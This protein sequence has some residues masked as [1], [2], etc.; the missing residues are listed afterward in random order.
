MPRAAVVPLRAGGAAGAP[1]PAPTAGAGASKATDVQTLL[2]SFS[3]GVQ[4]GLD[5]ATRRPG[6]GGVTAADTAWRS[7]DDAR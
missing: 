1:R 3:A 4:R 7:A 2:R 6:S 5:E